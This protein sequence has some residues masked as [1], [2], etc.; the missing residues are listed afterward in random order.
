MF[1]DVGAVKW[2]KGSLSGACSPEILKFYIPG[3]VF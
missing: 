2:P 1:Q 3:D